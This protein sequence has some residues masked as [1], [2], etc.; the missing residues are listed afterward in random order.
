MA[1]ALALMLLVALVFPVELWWTW[2]VLRVGS[3]I[4]ESPFHR[5]A[6]GR[7]R[8]KKATKEPTALV[9]QR[10]MAFAHAQM[11]SFI[12][13]RFNT[14]FSMGQIC[15]VLKHS[16]MGGKRRLTLSLT[17][18]WSHFHT[19]SSHAPSLLAPAAHAA[20]AGP[21]STSSISVGLPG[22]GD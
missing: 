20:Q 19:I 6:G 14:G 13:S 5:E 1:L 4:V 17:G 16:G 3:I 2:H 9:T 18:L 7:C 12:L 10:G 15:L 8:R 21:G 22:G 11:L